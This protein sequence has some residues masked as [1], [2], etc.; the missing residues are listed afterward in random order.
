MEQKG[1][2]GTILDKITSNES[3]HTSVVK[4]SRDTTER[5][6]N[7]SPTRGSTSNSNSILGKLM[8]TAKQ[9]S[10]SMFTIDRLLSPLL[11]RMLTD[12]RINNPKT[13]EKFFNSFTKMMQQLV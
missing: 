5:I 7:T 8:A 1:S 11:K 10:S 9:G 4:P 6:G 3:H 13:A 12:E 2:G